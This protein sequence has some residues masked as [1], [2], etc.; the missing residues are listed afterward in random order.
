MEITTYNTLHI[1][2]QISKI[3]YNSFEIVVLTYLAKTTPRE[4][5]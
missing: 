2:A 1:T 3:T 4:T 5:A